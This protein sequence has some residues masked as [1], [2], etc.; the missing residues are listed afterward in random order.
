M[1]EGF[2]Q[3]ETMVGSKNLHSSAL[4]NDGGLFGR[5]GVGNKWDGK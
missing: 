2:R 5:V 1:E 4:R 3:G